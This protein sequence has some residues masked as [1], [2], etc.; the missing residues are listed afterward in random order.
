MWTGRVRDTVW[1]VHGR[2]E[3]PGGL[4]QVVRSS[5]SSMDSSYDTKL[6]AADPLSIPSITGEGGRGR[7]GGRWRE[8]EGE[9]E[10]RGRGREVEG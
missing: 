1:M 4:P 3:L 6:I 8:V 5:G 10:G 9:R 2:E 7:R